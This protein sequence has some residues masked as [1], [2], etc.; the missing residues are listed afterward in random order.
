MSGEEGGE[1]TLD[2][3]L[4]AYQALRG[5]SGKELLKIAEECEEVEVIKRRY[6][7]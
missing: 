6:R 3:L 2:R 7:P 4:Y 1:A 5:L